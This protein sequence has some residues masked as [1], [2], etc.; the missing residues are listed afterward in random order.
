MTGSPTFCRHPADPDACRRLLVAEW[1]EGRLARHCVMAGLGADHAQCREVLLRGI[2]PQ[3]GDVDP[4]TDP[5]ATNGV[6]GEALRKACEESVLLGYASNLPAAQQVFLDAYHRAIRCAV[7]RFGITEAGEPGAEDLFQEIV[8]GLHKRLLKGLSLESCSLATYVWRAA[9]H[10]CAKAASAKRE[11]GALDEEVPVR[12]I[13]PAREPPVGILPEVTEAWEELDQALRRSDQGNLVNRIILAQKCLAGY[14]SGKKCPTKRLLSE[15]QRLFRLPAD[16]LRDLHARAAAE[17]R[18]FPDHGPVHLTA[19]FLN[20]GLA[21]TWQAAVVFAA[22]VGTDLEGTR[23][24][25]S[26][27]AGL[28]ENAVYTRVCRMLTALR[29]LGPEGPDE[30][31]R[32]Q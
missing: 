1:R 16:E 7:A 17:G 22:G 13:W 12:R 25:V 19:E 10:A 9:A 27:L 14:R 32:R 5:S 29:P 15:W 4:D 23:R 18:R 31:Q 8:L 30:L 20:E 2:R 26:R 11:S 28:S 21:E 6:S 24:L 3:A